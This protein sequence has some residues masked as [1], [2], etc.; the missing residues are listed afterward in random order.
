MDVSRF[1]IRLTCACGQATELTCVLAKPG[2]K[3][4]IPCACGRKFLLQSA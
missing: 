2:G 3:A 4:P 1:E